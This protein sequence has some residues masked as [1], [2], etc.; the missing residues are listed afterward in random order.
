[1]HVSAN[2]SSPLEMLSHQTTSEVERCVLHLTWSAP[3]NIPVEDVDHYM[4]LING[5]NVINQTS[6]NSRRNLLAHPVC[7]CGPHNVSITAVN[8]CSQVGQST[9]NMR[10]TPKTLPN[11]TCDI[12]PTK[13]VVC[14]CPNDGK[15]AHP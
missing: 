1:M 13:P 3:D 5:E 12:E 2:A 10:V 9:P 6:N 4:I 8:R 7:V 14:D 15:F 11:I